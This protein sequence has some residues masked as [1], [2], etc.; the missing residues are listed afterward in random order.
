MQDGIEKMKGPMEC[1]FVPMSCRKPRER[2]V[3]VAAD[4]MSGSDI[5]ESKDVFWM[6]NIKCDLRRRWV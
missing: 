6:A 2:K 1:I 5:A 4:V 3:Y